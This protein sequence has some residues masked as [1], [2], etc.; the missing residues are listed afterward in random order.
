MSR[1]LWT[2]VQLA[3]LRA[4][5][6]VWRIPELTER[7]NAHFGTDRTATSVHTCIQHHDMRCGRKPGL[8]KGESYRSWT[9]EKVAWLRKHRASGPI[10]EITERL[11]AK[12]NWDATEYMVANACQR[13]GIQAA[14]TGRFRPGNRPWNLGATGY[15]PGG[16]S[17]STR[18]RDG[19]RPHTEV[20]VGSYKQDVQG[21]W[22]LKVSDNQAPTFS[23]RNWRL[24][25]RLTWEGVHGPIPTGHVVV[26]LDGNPDHCLDPS[27]CACISRSV[28]V[29]LN[30]L[31][32]DALCPD[33]EARRAVVALASVHAVSHAR[34]KDIGLSLQ[35]RRAMIAPLSRL[36][37]QEDNQ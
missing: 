14:E 16:R 29:R 11:N 25:H 27:N 20:P 36:T 8:A 12:F 17:A 21:Y 15:D 23:R 33:R 1:R 30:A 6:R 4:G 3:W 19:N 10:G 13:Y 26:L 35:H 5:Y 24:V 34:A 37:H 9:P 28:L 32:W 2:N 7:F 31:G 22:Y 18:F